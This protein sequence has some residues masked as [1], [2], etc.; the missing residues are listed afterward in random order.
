MI[1]CA[2]DCGTPLEDRDERGRPRRYIPN[3]HWRG[4]RRLTH[5]KADANKTS[6]HENARL[7]ARGRTSCE[8][9]AIG[10]CKGILDVHHRDGNPWNN[11][12]ENLAKLCRSH[13]RLIESDRIDLLAP[14]MPPFYVDGSGKRRYTA[15]A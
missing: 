13:H 14:V 2:C 15:A 1:L 6:K 12:P 4:R 11:E 8:L 5:E 10:G 3:H 7:R 9:A